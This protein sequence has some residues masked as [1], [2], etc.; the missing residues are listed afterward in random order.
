MVNSK[1]MLQFINAM[2]CQSSSQAKAVSG[3]DFSCL[4]FIFRMSLGKVDE[5]GRFVSELDPQPDLEKAKTNS[6]YLPP[7]CSLYSDWK[8]Y[9][10]VSFH[11]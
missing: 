11:N 5:L 6:V 9:M 3:N 8:Y 7:F 2:V 10:S 4:L 1:G